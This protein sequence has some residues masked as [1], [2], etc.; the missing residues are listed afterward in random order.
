MDGSQFKNEEIPW[1]SRKTAFKDLWTKI[2]FAPYAG[3]FLRMLCEPRAAMFS[4]SIALVN[5]WISETIIAQNVEKRCIS[6]ASI[7][8]AW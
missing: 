8:T 3:K 6:Q 5:G 7:G 1:E 2:L 4:A